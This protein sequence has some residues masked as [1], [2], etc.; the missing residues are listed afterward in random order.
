MVCNGF[1]CYIKNTGK[2]CPTTHSSSTNGEKGPDDKKWRSG[3]IFNK[4]RDG[5]RERS[6]AEPWWMRDDEK[7]N[8][9]VLPEY[10]PW[11]LES[12]PIVDTKWKLDDLKAEA[13]RRGL[14]SKGKKEQ[15]LHILKESSVVH[16]LSDAGYVQPLYYSDE[17]SNHIPSCYP[18]VY[19]DPVILRSL[20]DISMQQ[21]P[22]S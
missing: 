18:E 15:L 11:W 5:N 6:G 19:E 17:K 10:V 9:R 13:V 14:S 8:P 12:N 7:N 2:S 20:Q 21:L 16:D 3:Q 1:Q 4:V 22:P